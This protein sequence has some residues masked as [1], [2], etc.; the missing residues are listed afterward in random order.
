MGS[1]EI[2][3]DGRVLGLRHRDRGLHPPRRPAA[4]LR[5]RADRPGDHHEPAEG[6]RPCRPAGHH[7]GRSA[8][9]LSGRYSPLRQ[10]LRRG[11]RDPSDHRAVRLGRAGAWPSSAKERRWPRAR[12]RPRGLVHSYFA[13]IFGPPQ[14][15]DL[16]DQL[17]AKTF[18]AAFR[19]GASSGRSARGWASPATKPGPEE[20]AKA[21]VA[22]ISGVGNAS[23]VSP[24]E[25]G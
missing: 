4:R 21:L 1:L 2:D 15:K 11:R 12:P 14:Y 19:S 13:N 8:A 23:R 16:H 7:D 9:R 20:A 25:T 3:A 22:L 5:L 17:G 24:I 10:Q 6:Q 18:E